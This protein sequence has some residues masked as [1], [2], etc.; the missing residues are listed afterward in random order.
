[1]YRVIK[2]FTDLKDGNHP[3]NIGD[4]YPRN[5]LDVSAERITELASSSNQRGIPLIEEVSES[6]TLF[7][8]VEPAEDVP[9][10]RGRKSTK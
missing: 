7:D 3:Y 5:G 2:F 4:T 1:M 9:K 6:A 10:K 8:A